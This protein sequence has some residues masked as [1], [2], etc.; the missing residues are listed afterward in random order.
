M[1]FHLRMEAGSIIL[2]RVQK[3]ME[4]SAGVLSILI[5]KKDD[6]DTAM[7]LVNFLTLT[8]VLEYRAMSQER[9]VSTVCANA[10]RLV[11]VLTNEL[12][13]TVILQTAS[14]NVQKILILVKKVK[15][16]LKELA[17]DVLEGTRV[18]LKIN[19]VVWAKEIVIMIPTAK[20]I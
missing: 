10:D 13:A 1:F 7:Q 12:V 11:L 5:T 17:F 20:T 3:A 14:A 2:V 6:G 15:H 16:V 8:P 19:R 4:A 18:A 9:P